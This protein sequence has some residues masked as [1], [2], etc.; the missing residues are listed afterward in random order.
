MTEYSKNHPYTIK[1]DKAM[2][3]L[4]KR[5]DRGQK[6]SFRA[7]SLKVIHYLDGKEEVRRD[8]LLHGVTSTNA[9]YSDD[10]VDECIKRLHS[11]KMIK[12]TKGRYSDVV[13]A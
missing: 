13:I 1:F 10:V 5:L 8:D 6:K 7:L 3:A 2:R 4:T 11:Q 9:N 12:V